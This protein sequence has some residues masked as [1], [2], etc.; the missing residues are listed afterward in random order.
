MQ[1]CRP[2]YAPSTWTRC[3]TPLTHSASDVHLT[4]VLSKLDLLPDDSFCLD[5]L[6]YIA[7]LS[8]PMEIAKHE[9]YI[10]ILMSWSGRGL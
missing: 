6:A 4:A 9:I 7:M 8:N 10:V 5:W 3:F 2:G 1:G